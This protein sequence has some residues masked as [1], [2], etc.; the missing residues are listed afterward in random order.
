MTKQEYYDLLISSAYDGTFPSVSRHSN[1]TISCRY[2]GEKPGSKCAGGLLIPD[3]EYSIGFEGRSIE[4][5]DVARVVKVPDGMTILDIRDCQ[6]VHDVST[7][8]TKWDPQSFISKINNLNC[9]SDVK[10]V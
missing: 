10:K 3:E 9:F 2:R 8:S 7:I 5:V 1:S 6:K 4:Q